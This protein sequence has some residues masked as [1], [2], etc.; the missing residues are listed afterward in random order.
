MSNSIP[1]IEDADMML[2][3]G[4]NM[5]EC[6]PIIAVRVKK[7]VR[8]GAK[9]YV[10][11]PRKI[12]LTE[13]ATGHL[14]LK[15]GSDV[16]L[17]NA[18]AKVIIDEG[19][20][21]M[22][23]SEERTEGFEEL[24]KH[25]EPF[26]IEY[27]EE[28][29]GV[30][31][32][33][34]RECAI[35]YAS[36]ESAGIYYTLGIT[37]HICGVSNVQSLCNLALITGNLGKRS[38]G[39]NPLRGQNNIQGAGD[40]GALPNNY[41]GFQSVDDPVSQA[42]FEK[43]WGVPM[44]PHKG[45]T[46]IAALDHAVDGRIKAM[47]ICGENTLVTDPDVKHTTKAL[48]SLDFLVV[49]DMFLTDTAKLA[50]VVFPAAA[51]TEVDGFF[52]N[53]DRRVQRIRKAANPPGDAMPDWWIIAH[54]AKRMTNDVHFDYENSEQVFDELASLSPIYA[55]LNY[56]RIE[57]G[58][59]A[60]PVPELDHPGT[61]I[62]HEGEFLNGKGKLQLLNYVP[63]SENPDEEYPFYLTTG[64]R[65]PTYHSNTMT[66]RSGGFRI[67]VPNEWLEIHP[68]DAEKLGLEDGDW[69]KIK[70]RRGEVITRVAITKTSPRGT[71]F[72]SFAFPEEVMTNIV[73]NP[74]VDPKTETPE[75][76]VAAVSI[77]RVEAPTG[78]GASEP[79]RANPD[80]EDPHLG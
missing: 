46:K 55:G 76:K 62:L 16:A 33:L 37:E 26:T 58:D 21:D 69:S 7:A 48:E 47:W 63:P 50:D 31:A 52:T 14:P 43:A 38:D 3:V 13:Y 29:S 64:R 20:A 68:A 65:L 61:P 39:V 51:F 78:L 42:K 15:L 40:T 70:S 2:C 5:T 22:E 10:V 72:M 30:P 49:Q 73:T 71:V 18:M 75:F 19:L 44:D 80:V 53:S 57:R 12:P 11:D 24:K 23:Y 41:P 45:I 32:K 4:T 35:A 1:E 56:D 17:F 28:I 54:V 8:K 6:H 27:G 36:A 34:I 59:L 66:G 60:W 67:L 74:E 77:V 9:L 25:L 79:L